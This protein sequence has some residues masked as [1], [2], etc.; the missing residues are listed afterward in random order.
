MR[1]CLRRA[2][3]VPPRWVRVGHGLDGRLRIRPA[4]RACGKA[5]G[6]GCG[7]RC[8]RDRIGVIRGRGLG[9][10]GSPIVGRYL[11]LFRRGGPAPSF[12]SEL[13]ER[14]RGVSRSIS[15][16]A[17]LGSG[18]PIEQRHLISCVPAPG[19]SPPLPRPAM[20][21]RRRRARILRVPED[22]RPVRHFR[23]RTCATDAVEDRRSRRHSRKT[24]VAVFPPPPSGSDA[25]NFPASC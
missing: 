19:A 18:H 25:R 3:G 23:I 11:A 7:R 1:A 8:G 4:C 14:L 17:V 10:P 20:R 9:S 12:L 16:S 22:A 24:T 15:S 21:R 13:P 5:S 2:P 6:A